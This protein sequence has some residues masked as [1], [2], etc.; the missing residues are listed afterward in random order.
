MI[1]FGGDMFPPALKADRVIGLLLYE[2]MSQ[3]SEI[4]HI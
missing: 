2:E 1:F 3:F 4:I